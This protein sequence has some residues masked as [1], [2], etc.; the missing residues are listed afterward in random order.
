VAHREHLKANSSD[1]VI[2]TYNDILIHHVAK[3][4]RERPDLNACWYRDGIHTYEAIHIAMAVD[5]PDGL[6]APVLREADRLSLHEIATCTLKLI[7]A[8]RSGQL[9]QNQLSG[10]TFTISNLG[11]LGV[12][13]FTPVLNMP[14]AAILGV[15]R[16]VEEPIV[17]DGQLVAGKTMS[18]SLTFDHRV[19]DGAPA[20]RWLQRLCERLQSSHQ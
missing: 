17:L 7:N 8:A 16:I 6:L 18:L 3:T 1:G 15:G 19:I 20:A 9:N 4:L 13:A 10:G 11:M 14:Q 5:T 12:D 2:P